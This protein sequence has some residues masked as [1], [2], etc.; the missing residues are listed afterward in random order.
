ME[1]VDLDG[2][3]LPGRDEWERERLEGGVDRL[4]DEKERVSTES[5]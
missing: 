5:R 4:L 2:L 1:E 3:R